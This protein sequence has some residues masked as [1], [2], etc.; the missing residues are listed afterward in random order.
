MTSRALRISAFPSMLRI[1]GALCASLSGAAVLL[2]AAGLLPVYFF[3]SVVAAP[4][5]V[6]LLLL[7]IYAK[8]INETIFVNRLLVGAWGGLVATFSYDLVRYVLVLTGAVSRNPFLSHPVFGSLITGHPV[9]S[10]VA[11]AVGWAYHFWNGVSFGVMYT[12]V[13][14]QGRWLWGLIWALVLEIAWL[15]ALPSVVHFQLN[16]E[17]LILSFTGHGLYGVCLGLLARRFVKE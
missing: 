6:L 15:S 9:E 12:L 2:H 11:I 3:V 4:A 14:G 13:V 17:F 5:M 8:R 7:G 1:V 16:S 10:T